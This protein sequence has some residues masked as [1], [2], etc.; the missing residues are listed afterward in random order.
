MQFCIFQ[1][2]L[3]YSCSL[4]VPFQDQR[5]TQVKNTESFDSKTEASRKMTFHQIYNTECIW[6]YAT[7]LRLWIKVVAFVISVMSQ[8]S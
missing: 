8:I 5:Q 6:T 1:T 2:E 7:S 4:A 3:N